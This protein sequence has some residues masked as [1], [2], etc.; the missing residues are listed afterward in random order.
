MEKRLYRSRT[1]RMLGGVCGGLGEYLNIDPT[2]ARL[3][4]VLLALGNGIGLLLYL[5]A[6][7][8]LPREDLAAASREEAMREG[9]D[10]IAARAREVGADVRR[11]VQSSQSQTG[12]IVGG[13]LIILGVV[14]L[15]DRIHIPFLWWLNLHVLWPLLLIGVGVALL[16]RRADRG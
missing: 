1:D 16:L 3:F 2:L 9:A 10:E 6:W 8:V 13:G 4:F 12:L 14:F 11:V 7:I 5:L 15:L